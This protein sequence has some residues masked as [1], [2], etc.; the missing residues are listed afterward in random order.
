LRTGVV[1][2][3]LLL[4]VTGGVAYGRFNR[5]WTFF[6]DAPATLLTVSS[7]RSKLGWTAGFG[8]EWAFLGNWSLKSEVLYTRFV[9]DQQTFTG[10][11]GAIGIAG[12]QYRLESQ[13]SMWVS[14]IGLN[15][16]FGGGPVYAAY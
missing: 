3:N 6:E 9:D 7:D 10:A 4:Y 8:T 12:R 16:R 5:N 2:N 1:V 13:D 15:Y 14:R 11:F